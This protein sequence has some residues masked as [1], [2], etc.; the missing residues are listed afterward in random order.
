M[1]YFDD[2]DTQYFTMMEAWAADGQEDQLEW[3]CFLAEMSEEWVDE[4]DHSDILLGGDIETNPGWMVNNEEDKTAC[5]RST[6]TTTR[7]GDN[8]PAGT[9]DDMAGSGPTAENTPIEPSIGGAGSIQS[10]TPPKQEKGKEKET[11]EE[12]KEKE[13]E[14]EKENEE[15][16]GLSGEWLNL[17]L[18][19]ETHR[20]LFGDQPYMDV[21]ENQIQKQNRDPKLILALLDRNLETQSKKK[22]PA[23]PTDKPSVFHGK[24]H[25]CGKQGHMASQCKS[26][27]W[28]PVGRNADAKV[29]GGLRDW[30]S[31]IRGQIDALKEMR[32]DAHDDLEEE[33]DEEEEA[34]DEGEHDGGIEGDDMV[35]KPGRGFD[36]DPG[37]DDT[38]LPDEVH[39]NNIN[40]VK[41][42]NITWRRP[43]PPS[44]AAYGLLTTF[45]SLVS[46]RTVLWYTPMTHTELC[47]KL[48]NYSVVNVAS[49][50]VS[51][52]Q[53]ATLRHCI[54]T[55]T[56]KGLDA[57]C[58]QWKLSSTYT[59][60]E[61]V[62]SRG[63]MPMFKCLLA[64][65]ALALAFDL[66]YNTIN[67]TP[68]YIRNNPIVNYFL[69]PPMI[70]YKL[71]FNK[72]LADPYAVQADRRHDM[73]S[74]SECKHNNSLEAEL[75]LTQ[76]WGLCSSSYKFPV[77]MSVVVQAANF[78][79]IHHG[80]DNETSRAK[81]EQTLSRLGTVNY[82]RFGQLSEKSAIENVKTVTGM[83]RE[84]INYHSLGQQGFLNPGGYEHTLLVQDTEKSGL[85]NSLIS[86]LAP[87][88]K[89]WRFYSLVG[90]LS[91]SVLG[92]M[93]GKQPYSIRTLE[94]GTPCRQELASDLPQQC[95]T[96]IMT[97]PMNLEILWKNSVTSGSR[98]FPLMSIWM[99]KLGSAIAGI[100]SPA[101]RS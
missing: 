17:S 66:T 100:L 96:L 21:V 71:K 55:G 47:V 1:Q 15:S 37:G 35:V 86:S 85:P 48:F 11:E 38:Y 76:K 33:E 42:F 36:R 31:Q 87:D 88:S 62:Q 26:V 4:N 22:F 52:G 89:N 92:L 45:G 14:K 13:K 78:S 40:S 32:Q 81:V 2:L 59:P 12:L 60:F 77:Y 30:E 70:N 67:K 51:E 8:E 74:V 44:R 23:S 79:N 95:L 50:T 53:L 63:V 72:F 91:V 29:A 46:L 41:M 90:L 10:T 57:L 94:I 75:K 97:L 93:Y 83:I 58:T 65:A 39:S 73:I 28:K 68:P 9:V 20:R 98:L 25:K 54:N 99:S 19:L 43:S 5:N 3:D 80:M 7:V 27:Q 84:A 24:C 16:R 34:E 82:N 69:G 61:F 6:L 49:P 56:R 64:G 101:G 18:E